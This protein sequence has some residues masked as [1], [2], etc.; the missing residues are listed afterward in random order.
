MSDENLD[1]E[2]EEI[3]SQV[4]QDQQEAENV[5]KDVEA[6]EEEV[7]S[8]EE[9]S[10][11]E[12]QDAEQKGSQKELADAEEKTEEEIQ[13]EGQE[14]E[15]IEQVE[16]DI[17][18]EINLEEK[19]EQLLEKMQ[20]DTRE[21][22]KDALNNLKQEKK[23]LLNAKNSE[24]TQIRPQDYQ[25]LEEVLNEF[26]DA[27]GN[28]HR[29]TRELEEL[30]QEIGRTEDEENYLEK[31]TSR[32]PKELDFMENEV[33][34]LL[35]DFKKLQDSK[36]G[37]MA[38]KEGEQLTQ[39]EQREQKLEQME[40]KVDQELQNE[41]QEAENLVR[42]D[43]QII[44][45]IDQSISE[46]EEV[47][48]ILEQEK[49][50]WRFAINKNPPLDDIENTIEM[51][52]KVMGEDESELQKA[53]KFASNLMDKAPEGPSANTTAKA[54]LKISKWLIIAV[55]VLFAILLVWMEIPTFT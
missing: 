6:K 18:E 13:E 43:E 23:K 22:L 40:Q 14:E 38:K 53:G 37:K 46:L 21:E 3:E 54:G 24:N 10:G 9:S 5:E 28:V 30:L 51:L 11:E 39:L 49:S 41:L 20:K 52:E 19:Q 15:E 34:E 27:A 29:F 45:V 55:V 33:E 48:E 7:E 26:R 50:I 32:L 16:E 25:K 12:I 44:K 17:M 35:A 8:K 36:H 31:L 47:Y 2:F 1:E 42:D 4:E